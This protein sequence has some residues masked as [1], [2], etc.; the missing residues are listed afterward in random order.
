M[1]SLICAVILAAAFL[2][3]GCYSKICDLRGPL[4][5]C[6]IHHEYMREAL[7]SNRHLAMPSQEYLIARVQ[8]F[9]HSYPFALPDQCD[10]TEVYICD[11]CVKA[12]RAWRLAHPE[13]K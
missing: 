6:Q 2:L 7:I 12:E 9:P 8:F 5:V 11:D 4:D 10:K 13:Q 1:R 3:T